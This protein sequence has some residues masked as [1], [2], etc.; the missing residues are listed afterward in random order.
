MA[1]PGASSTKAG[2]P[3]SHILRSALQTAA[4]I[5]EKGSTQR[6]ARLAYVD[7]PSGGIFNQADLRNGEQLLIDCGLIR[8]EAGVLYPVA[9]LG[10]LVRAEPAEAL[11]ILFATAVRASPPPWLV[12]GSPLLAGI[13]AEAQQVLA[14]LIQD[15]DRREAFLIA[16]ANSDLSTRRELAAL[17]EECVVA[18]ARAE[19]V[20]LDRPDLADMVSRVS[21]YTDTLGYDV[22]APLVRGGARR[23][24]VKT[25]RADV[26]SSCAV[27]I[28]RNEVEVGLRDRGW[29]LVLC[30]ATN[31]DCDVVGWCRGPSLAPYLPTDAAG[32]RWLETRLVLPR[33]IFLPSMPPAL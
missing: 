30:R 5:D 7:D 28:S 15:P 25:T 32:S 11:Q 4:L 3:T 26:S 1:E 6:A 31:G 29:A 19:L 16:I 17:G 24:E 8:E 13:P 2:L 27:F 22:T 23:L 21:I 18:V 14:E 10:E 9:E 12:Q 33:T 20:L